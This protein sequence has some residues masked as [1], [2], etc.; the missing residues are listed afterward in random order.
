MDRVKN[1]DLGAVPDSREAGEALARIVR[2]ELGLG[3]APL[4]DIAELAEL[5]FGID[6]LNWPTGTGISGLCVKGDGVALML[7]ST[8]F[9]RGHQ[10]FTAA[11]EIGHYLFSDPNAIIFEDDL[12]D[13]TTPLE[14]RANAFAESF[15]LPEDGLREVIGERAIDDGLIAELMRHFGVSYQGLIYR[16]RSTGILSGTIA[17][18]WFSKSAG[19]VLSNANDQAPEELTKQTEEKR[20][21]PRLWRAAEKGYK[22]GRVGLGILS[23]LGEEEGEMLFERL[24]GKGILPPEIEDDYSEITDILARSNA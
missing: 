3:R 22:A 21:P 10:R 13:K 17:K 19:S 7:V 4:S 9:P 23:M 6:V 12:F 5:H 24:A 8:S 18:Q 14:M 20:V 2:E 16:F 11:H 1:E 15:L